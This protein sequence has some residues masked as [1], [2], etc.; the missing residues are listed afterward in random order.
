MKKQ[1]NKGITLVEM[2]VALAVGS[3]V[4]SAVVILLQQGISGYSRQ[5]IT[6]QLQDD[7]NITLNQMS[8]TIM[9]AKCVDIYN[10]E[11]GEKNTPKFIT[12]R[13]E[14]GNA[15]T[16]NAYS[17]DINNHILYV[18]APQTNND[19]TKLSILCKNVWYF[20]VQ[21]LNSSVKIEGNG[22]VTDPS[23]I[24]KYKYKITEINNPI[25]IKVTLVLK[26]KYGDS[27]ITREVS[28]VSALR[29]DLKITNPGLP[30]AIQGTSVADFSISS[31]LD[32][33]FTD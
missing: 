4:I 19:Y 14:N 24:N 21:I 9:Q 7:A 8:D 32:A 20:K 13:G 11:S 23:G 16:G 33:Y 12:N 5:T 22:V 15:A 27:F 6:T 10:E 26:Y 25:Q 31:A 2:L 29:N 17:Y 30:L 18:G 28:R 3:I 1:N